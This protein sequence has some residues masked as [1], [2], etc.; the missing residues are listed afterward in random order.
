MPDNVR[1]RFA[2]S[3]TGYLHVGGLRTA[4][5]NFLFARHHNGVLVLRI[6]D[7]DQT[8]YVEG[9][10][11]KLIQ[12]LK[13][14]G[15]EY[16]EGPDAGGNY[17]PYL[18]S[19]RL[20]TYREHAQQ[21]IENDHAY[22]CFCTPEDLEKMREHQAANGM[23]PKYDGSCR[24]LSHNEVN[25]KIDQGIS[26][27]IRLKMPDE[28]N[29]TFED[30]I[31]GTVSFQNELQDDQILLKS[32]GFPTYHLANVIDDHLMGITHVIRGEEW[33][34]SLPKHIQLYKA[35]GWDVPKL[36]HLP[37]LLN[38]DR[39]KLSKRQGDV[40]VEDYQE[41]GYLPEALINFLA[42]L[43]WNPGTDQEFFGMG[44]LI[45]QFSLERVSKSGAVFDIEKLNWMNGHYIR[46]LPEEE[47]FKFLT[48]FFE[49]AGFD[50][51]D[52]E[53]TEKIISGIYKKVDKGEDVK[54]E[55]QIF[56]QDEIEVTED[57][58]LEI[59]K[60]NGSKIVLEQFL[61]NLE[62]AG[63]LNVD[64]F[65]Q[66]MKEVQSQTGVKKQDLWMPIR[67]ALTGVTHGAE[68]PLI[69]EIFGKQKV[70]SFVKQ[71]LQ[72]HCG[73]SK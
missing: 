34:L 12:A 45:E 24:Q 29:T 15:I 10:V 63:E 50:V 23:T 1:V 62:K 28:G 16:D 60:K 37:L 4:L 70:E 47:R 7:T 14:A 65:K 5:Y 11:E 30:I 27:V 64:N 41:K 26:R 69:I 38:T 54:R 56:Y 72:K 43:G 22:Y 9:A 2:P 21:L 55:A 67:I 57:E 66:I 44:E 53:K 49:K 59:L 46:E 18:Q 52:K 32:D 39:S 58:A 73:G 35:F 17:G 40:A 20:S 68:L 3:P 8:R 19:E 6:E 51:S 61:E 13:W 71:I 42:L 33:L 31:R 36:S 48:S 25:K